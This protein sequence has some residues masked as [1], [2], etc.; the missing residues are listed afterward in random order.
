MD[1]IT[2]VA[3]LKNVIQDL[4]KERAVK[5]KLLKDQAYQTFESFKPAKVLGMTIKE[6]VTSPQVVG[7]VIDTAIGLATGYYSRRI[8]VGTSSNIIRR[9]LGTVVQAGVTKFVANHT[10]KV[11]SFG[12]LAF[13]QIFRKKTKKNDTS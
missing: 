11:K 4:E 9:L 6:M 7:N 13:L 8:L 1:N 12:K 3:G 5:E 2:S 10:D